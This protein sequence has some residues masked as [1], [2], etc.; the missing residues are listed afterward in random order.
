MKIDLW[1]PKP[2]CEHFKGFLSIKTYFISIK[3]SFM[4]IKTG[5]VGIR[6]SLWVFWLLK[7]VFELKN[8]FIRFFVM[9]TLTLASCSR[10]LV[11]WMADRS[12]STGWSGFRI[13]KHPGKPSICWKNN[14]S[15]FGCCK[16][17]KM[18]SF[19]SQFSLPIIIFLLLK[20]YW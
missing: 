3:T 6:T 15:I 11:W 8:G 16:N 12:L 2:V 10:L 17:A 14:E 20:L 5:F 19:S 4:S 9:V 13:K 18:L 7:Q 1:V